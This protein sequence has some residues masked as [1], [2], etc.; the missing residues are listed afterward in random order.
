MGMEALDPLTGAP[1]AARRSRT[2]VLGG[3]ESIPFGGVAKMC[4]GQTIDRHSGF[5]LSH[6]ALRLEGRHR[7]AETR[8]DQPIPGR[9]RRS[10]KEKRGVGDDRGH[11]IVITD[12][13]IELAGRSTAEQCGDDSRLIRL[14]AA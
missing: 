1:H 4:L 7:L 5:G 9:H 3:D 13:D 14:I 2:S 11:A 6:P 8:V 12:N 10:V